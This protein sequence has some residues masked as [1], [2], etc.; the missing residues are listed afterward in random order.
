[1]SATPAKVALP[2]QILHQLRSPLKLRLVLG[3]VILGGWYFLFF[4]PLSEHMAATQASIDKERK[5]I[6]MA[7]KLE[8][9]RKS[10]LPFKDRVPANSDLNELL[11]FVMGRVRSSPLKLIDLKP[12]A[13][14]RFGPFDAISL[15]LSIDGT[16]DQILELL[17][18]MHNERRLIRV[19]AV[20][21]TPV[22]RS[23]DPKEASGPFKL[24]L[25]LK[26]TALME[27]S[28]SE[29]PPS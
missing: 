18:W 9:V 25:Q 24:H 3:P 21:L 11:Q 8:D 5:R 4:S 17:A 15:S 14:R 6:D 13:S 19:E 26:L 29:K 12:E 23:Q 27:M 20:S 16:H 7:S 1:M 28:G 2:K 10:L 22:A